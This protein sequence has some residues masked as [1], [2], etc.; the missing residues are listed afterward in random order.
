MK[1]RLVL[2]LAFLSALFLA[3]PL[4]R[5]QDGVQG[6][7]PRGNLAANFASPFQQQTLAVADFDGDH[8]PDGAVL[9]DSGLLLTQSG[10]RTIELHFTGRANTDLTFE[11]N[12][13]TL[14]I[15]ALDVNRDGA[16]DIVVEQSVTHKR[17]Q[18]WLNDGRG[19]FRKVRSDDYPFLDPGTRERADSPSERPDP[20][21]IGL[22]TQ[23]GSEIAF[24]RVGVLPCGP[25]LFGERALTF[26]FRSSSLALASISSR[27]PPFTFAL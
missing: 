12:Q 13:N 23:R 26:S 19:G 18:V 5:A 17:V 15:S 21:A 9:I 20:S 3:A 1:P 24:S 22:P 14:A 16:A 8:K 11:S 2:K 25:S 7:L 4:V 10:F 6:A 27:A